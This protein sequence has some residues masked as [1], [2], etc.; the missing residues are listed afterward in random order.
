MESVASRYGTVAVAAA[1]TVVPLESL[2]KPARGC[3]VP[4]VEAMS[5]LIDLCLS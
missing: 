4:T 1:E 5:L 3:S 2:A